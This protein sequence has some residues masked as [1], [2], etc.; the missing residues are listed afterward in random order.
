M[1]EF[2]PD[3][4]VVR[5]AESWHKV[6]KGEVYTVER[7]TGDGLFLRGHGNV[8]YAASG[9]ALWV[10]PEV[11]A[12]QVTKLPPQA[13]EL[14]LNYLKRRLKEA[15]DAGADVHPWEFHAAVQAGL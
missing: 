13:G 2:K 5:T 11:V 4:K 15:E 10:A 7:D 6:R 8:S 3:D 12:P 9:F 1:L 14:T